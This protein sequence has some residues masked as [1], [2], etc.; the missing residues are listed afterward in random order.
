MPFPIRRLTNAKYGL[1][2][3]TLQSIVSRER[4]ADTL[5]I[6]VRLSLVKA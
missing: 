5:Y 6:M 3:I 1:P 2:M 4:A